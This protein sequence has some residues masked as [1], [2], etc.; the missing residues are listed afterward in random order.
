MLRIFARLILALVIFMLFLLSWGLVLLVVVLLWLWSEYLD[1]K[2]EGFGPKTESTP[3]EKG[4]ASTTEIEIPTLENTVEVETVQKEEV[5]QEEAA[6]ADLV[7][8]PESVSFAGP[9]EAAAPSELEPDN[10]KRIE[11]IGP[12]LSSVLQEA[13]ITTFVGLANIT[14]DELRQILDD[15]GIGRIS[16]P[17]T[18]PEQ[19][20]LAAQ[21]DWAG[22]EALQDELKGGRRV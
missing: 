17:A 19:A 8:S 9:E 2:K 6:L 20:K 10:L 11:G 14:A 7:E 13:G 5:A 4:I 1:K 18:W 22:L 12:K 21:G 3:E 16:N 15:A